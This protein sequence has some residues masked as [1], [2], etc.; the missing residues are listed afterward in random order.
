MRGE[1]MEKYLHKLLEHK[2]ALIFLGGIATAY[3]GKKI[4]ESD[5]VKNACTEGMAKVLAVKK[6][7]EECFQDMKDNAEDIATDAS[8]KEKEKIYVEE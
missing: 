7:A 1:I 3:A 8:E 5:T 4:V 2:H 6:D